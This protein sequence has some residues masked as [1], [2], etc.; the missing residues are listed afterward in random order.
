MF[1]PLAS[2]HSELT[3]QQLSDKIN[4]LSSK[5]GMAMRMGSGSAVQQ[6]QMLMFHYQEEYQRRAAKKLEEMEQ[7][8]SNFKNIIDIK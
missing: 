4:E 1:H 6:M 5:M 3:D 2:N 8:S 7:M